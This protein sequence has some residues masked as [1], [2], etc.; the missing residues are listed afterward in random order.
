MKAI[1]VLALTV[2]MAMVLVACGGNSNASTSSGASSSAASGDATGQAPSE[3]Y[4][5]TKFDVTYN[6]GST[7]GNSSTFDDRGRRLTGSWE[8]ASSGC[9]SSDW[10]SS[11]TGLLPRKSPLKCTLSST[12]C[13]RV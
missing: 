4:M 6:D 2:A 5:R 11:S 12:P 13:L 8:M 7:M 9:P 1:T 3:S 10:A